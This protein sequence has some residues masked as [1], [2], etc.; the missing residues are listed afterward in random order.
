M[1]AIVETVV[2]LIASWGLKLPHFTALG[3]LLPRR[4]RVA[5]SLL[6]LPRRHCDSG[7]FLAFG[8]SKKTKFETCGGSRNGMV[9]LQQRADAAASA[10]P[11]QCRTGWKA[12]AGTSATQ[13]IHPCAKR[14]SKPPPRSYASV[15]NRNSLSNRNFLLSEHGRAPPDSNAGWR[16]QEMRRSL[17]QSRFGRGGKALDVLN[18]GLPLK[19]GS[20]RVSAA[21]SNLHSWSG[22]H[23]GS[24]RFLPS[25][26]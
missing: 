8:N 22:R 26:F 3:K 12:G 6:V 4:T 20:C 14:S 5:E 17:L 24:Q 16:N 19:H 15:L 1:M 11:C 2:E 23:C 21:G 13:V 7:Y 9:W 10:G 25:N 18:F